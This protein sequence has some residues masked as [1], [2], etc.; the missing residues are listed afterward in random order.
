MSIQKMVLELAEKAQEAA[1]C[2]ASFEYQPK[3]PLSVDHGR[4]LGEKNQDHPQGE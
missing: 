1:Q 3:E 4:G 2:P